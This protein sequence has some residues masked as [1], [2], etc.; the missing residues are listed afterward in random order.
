MPVTTEPEIDRGDTRTLTVAITAADVAADPSALSLAVRTPAGVTT[1]YV[2]GASAI[3]KDAVGS[4][5]YDLLF[6]EAGAWVYEWRSTNPTQVQGDII[7][8]QPSPIDDAPVTL[9]PVAITAFRL[10]LGDLTDPYLFTDEQAQYFL[11]KH[12]SNLLLAVADACDALAARF[13]RQF[14]FEANENKRFALSQRSKAYLAMGA[15]IRTRA[16][17]E[18]NS[19]GTG[20]VPT[21]AFPAP[22]DWQNDLAG[23]STSIDPVTGWP[24]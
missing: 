16:N 22:H 12:P 17:T 4:Y 24:L 2:Y 11:D 8:V 23:V 7:E 19:D 15:R 13:A 18:G 10:E 14:D 3:V 6:T 21:Y 20:G 5:H 9:D 1:T